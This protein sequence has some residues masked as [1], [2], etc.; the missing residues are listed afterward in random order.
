MTREAAVARALETHGDSEAIIHEAA[1]ELL[2]RRSARG[3][4]VDV[5]CGIGRFREAARDLATAYVGVDV[6]RHPE[7]P[8]DVTFVQA[9]LDRDP[10]PVDSASADIVAAIETVEHLENPHAFSRELTRVV[11]PGGWIVMTTPNQMSVLSLLSL[12]VKGRFAAFQD[13]YYPIHR[14]ALLPNDLVRIAGECGLSNAELA[15][16]ESGRIPLTGAH[17]P[18]TLSRIFPQACSDNVL[19]IARR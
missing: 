6:V 4:L 9:D 8:P 19:L 16:T 7:L 18:R 11:K 12:A 3:V 1:V 5:G 17:Y 15:F 2:R 13:E 10:I 14:S